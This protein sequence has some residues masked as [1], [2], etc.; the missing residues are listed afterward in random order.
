ME[1]K[2][3]YHSNGALRS[4]SVYKNDKIVSLKTYWSDGH[5]KIEVSCD[6]NEYVDGALKGYNSDGSSY[7]EGVFANGVGTYIEYGENEKDM[8]ST[9]FD[10]NNKLS[11]YRFLY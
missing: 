4:E 1:L 6:E 7:I 8:E 11:C 3:E 10:D 2:K 9:F 5:L